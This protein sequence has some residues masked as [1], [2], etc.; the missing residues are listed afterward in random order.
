MSFNL[1]DAFIG[2]IIGGG[3]TTALLSGA[4]VYGQAV[5]TNTAIVSFSGTDPTPADDTS[6]ATITLQ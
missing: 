3:Q 2:E 6:T 4:K 5:L 1:D